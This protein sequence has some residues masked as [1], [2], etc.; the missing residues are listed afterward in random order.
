[1]KQK[2]SLR[3]IQA[4]RYL[5]YS[6]RKFT[7]GVASVAIATG[8]LMVGNPQVQAAEKSEFSTALVETSSEKKLLKLAETTSHEVSEKPVVD[9][10]IEK[11]EVV[12]KSHD[13]DSKEGIV[14]RNH[15][16]ISDKA[17]TN[18]ITEKIQTEKLEE[19]LSKVEARLAQLPE[20]KET[21]SAIDSAKELVAK[22]H[23]LLKAED[24]TQTKVDAMKKQLSSQLTILNSMKTE[25]AEK[26]NIKIMIHVM[27]K[28]FQVMGK[29]GLEQHLLV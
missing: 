27:E 26:K 1:M 23:E 4:Q 5:R 18:T 3:A 10:T 14:E 19:Q 22:A 17:V 11:K 6:I 21:K 28:Q 29:V 7:V 16:E 15:E 9:K 25:V 8:I 24:K 12:D 2:Q 20:T 13:K